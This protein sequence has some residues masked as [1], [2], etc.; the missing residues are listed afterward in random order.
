MSPLRYLGWAAVT[1]ALLCALHLGAFVYQLGAPYAAEY[2]MGDSLVVKR[3]LLDLAA[4]S[5]ERKLVIAGGS[6]SLIGLD[7]RML[8]EALHVQTVNAALAFHLPIEYY[9][10]LIEP[11][12][13]PDDIVVLPLEYEYYTRRTPYIPE[14]SSQVLTWH[15][16]YFTG[17][18]AW[19]KV[20][21]LA[22]VPWHRVAGGVLAKLWQDQIQRQGPPATTNPDLVISIVH[23]RWRGEAITVPD[24]AY[25]YSFFHIDDHGD[26]REILGTYSWSAVT[27]LSKPFV[28]AEYPWNVLAEF[29][30]WCRAHHVWV[31]VTWPPTVKDPVVDFESPPIRA[32]VGAIMSRLAAIGIPILG[33]PTDVQFD[34]A[35][36]TDTHYHLSPEGK[37]QRTNLLI[38]WLKA[39]RTRQGP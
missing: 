16:E 15:T 14:F 24:S 3:H 19:Q 10:S 21:L 18:P 17:L 31:F 28:D 20:K 34:R 38:Q 23:R 36:F 27:S 39:V 35:L 6:S 29:A 1:L 12:L 13:K 2:W 9:F 25:Y 30:R 22:T 5:T 8:E 37:V 11:A 4:Q 26:V 32:H 7:S 33:S